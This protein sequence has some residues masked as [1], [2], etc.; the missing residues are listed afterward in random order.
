[1]AAR[2]DAGTAAVV[3]AAVST[4]PGLGEATEAERAALVAALERGACVT[5]ALTAALGEIN[6]QTAAALVRG[7]GGC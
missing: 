1:M 2:D 4:A 7:L 6:R 3:T 5:D